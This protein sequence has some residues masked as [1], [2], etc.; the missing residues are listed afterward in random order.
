[1]KL[2]KISC[3]FSAVLMA[4][5]L[6]S[7]PV[8]A[9]TNG[10]IVDGSVEINK[11]T[12]AGEKVLTVGEEDT[13]GS[14]TIKLQDTD[15]NLSKKDVSLAVTKVADVEGGEFKLKEAFES[16][17]MDLN[18]IQNTNE[19]EV[20]ATKLSKIVTADNADEILTT[21]EDGVAK[22]E[23]LEIGV[24]LIFATDT[25]AYEDITPSLVSI[26]TFDDESGNMIYDIEVLPKHTAPSQS[27]GQ[28]GTQVIPQTGVDN[29]AMEYAAISAGFLV[30]AGLTGIILVTSQKRKKAK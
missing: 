28:D 26:P 23:K 17:E 14:I 29:N 30:M 6:L 13:L 25:K 16:S 11:S 3:L 22:A 1:M 21:D 7:T 10:T 9:S 27:G 5:S 24:Y 4:V 20:A 2:K 19:L 15:N 12:N 8:L 18:N